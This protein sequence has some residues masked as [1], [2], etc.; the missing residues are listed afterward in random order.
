MKWTK[1]SGTELM[2]ILVMVAVVSTLAVFQYRW[3]GEISRTEQARLKTSLE[4]SVRNFDQEFSYDFQQLCEGFEIDPEGEPPALE[5]RVAR[6]YANWNRT[7]SHPGLVAGL[8]IWRTASV[9]ASKFESFSEIE[10]RFHDAD[11]P[12]QF[13]SLRKFLQQQDGQRPLVIG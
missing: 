3:T 9:S 8:Y 6:Q 13:E 11:W 12:P 10:K 5:S 1:R 4:T 2:A 7:D